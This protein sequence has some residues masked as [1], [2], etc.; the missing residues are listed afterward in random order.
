MQR[1][2]WDSCE[3]WCRGWERHRRR[4]QFCSEGTPIWEMLRWE[5]CAWQCDRS[6]AKIT[7]AKQGWQFTV[8]CI[9][10]GQGGSTAHCLRCVGA[11]GKA[12]ALS[13]H[14]GHQSQ[15]QQNGPVCQSLSLWPDLLPPSFQGWRPAPGARSHDPGGTGEAWLW[16][17]H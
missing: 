4:S 5:H 13:L 10:G 15:Q 17:L 16:T 7:S 12:G 9:P 6:E 11:T 3:W 8:G 2:G 1:S 14:M